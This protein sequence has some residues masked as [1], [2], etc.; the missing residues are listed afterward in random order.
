[1]TAGFQVGKPFTVPAAFP[2][3]QNYISPAITNSSTGGSIPAGTYYVKMTWLTANGGESLPF[4]LS[5]PST[6]TGGATSTITA[7]NQ[8]G[9]W[10]IGVTGINVYIGSVAGQESLQATIT[11]LTGGGSVTITS[12]VAGRGV[13]IY[14]TTSFQDINPS[15]IGLS[16]SSEFIIHNLYYNNPVGV[17]VWDGTT[18]VMFDGDT[19]NGAREK[20]A[21]HCNSNQWIRVYNQSGYQSLQVSF[22]GMQTQ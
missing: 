14:N 2:F 6:A 1:M 8:A 3:A 12:L 17:G 13:P 5:E 15:A 7:T 18:A 19:G 20:V 10:P 4:H 21:H 9:A 16:N 22:D 11:G